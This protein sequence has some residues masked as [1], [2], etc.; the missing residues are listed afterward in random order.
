M[1]L[2]DEQVLVRRAEAGGAFLRDTWIKNVRDSQGKL[3]YAD[4]RIHDEVPEA[5]RARATALTSRSEP[6]AN[7]LAR[8]KRDRPALAA[9]SWVRGPELEL[10]P[11][12]RLSGWKLG[13]VV[14]YLDR[15]SDAFTRLTVSL[16]GKVEAS[17]V[18]GADY[19]DAPATVFPSGPKSSS[20][21]DVMLRDLRETG[22]LGSARAQVACT[23]EPSLVNWERA[24]RS[25]RFSPLD[26]RF[27]AVQAYFYVERALRWFKEKAGIELSSSLTVD[28][29]AGGTQAPRNTACYY[30]N[31]IRIGAGDGKTY[32][33]L[34]RDPSV[35]MHEVSHAVIEAVSHL[36]TQEEGGSINEAFADFFAASILDSPRMGEVSYVPGPYKRSLENASVLADKNGGLYHDSLIV[37]GTLW[38][39]RKLL[40]PEKALRF[41]LKTLARL[42][43]D[44]DFAG[45]RT[46]MRFVVHEGYSAE[47]TRLVEGVLV[48]R[49]LE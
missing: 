5:I 22:G 48:K 34:M 2:G 33:D 11:R 23:D 46:A 20:L 8:L 37:S 19:V 42:N 28:V 26:R 18:V 15:E 40:G 36:P 49:G 31:I 27:D 16:Q 17:R 4:G 45:L 6:A 39:M 1:R 47:E 3:V 43:P 32:R 21:E 29:F 41:A 44:S 13:W 25:Y 38:E 24:D 30:F 9:V 12:E 35:V 7:I 10:S 14:D